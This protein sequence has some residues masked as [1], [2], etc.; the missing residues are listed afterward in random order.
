MPTAVAILVI[1]LWWEGAYDHLQAPDFWVKVPGHGIDD[2][3]RGTVA[4]APPVFNVTLRVDNGV[5]RLPFCTGR[6]SA[7]VAYAGV[8][9]AHA[10]LPTGFCVPGRVVSS[11]P[12][13]ATSDGLG[14]PDELYERMESQ[15][16]RHERVS[17]EVQVKLEDCDGC[18]PFPAMLWCIAV[19][20]GQPQEGPF[21]CPFFYMVK[22]GQRSPCIGCF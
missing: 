15:R 20:H 5:T 10:D 6:A 16:R 7:V 18:G 13:V 21:R 1:H 4:V 9:L 11:V 14:I 3:E 19:L 8:Q 22:G 17:L 2:L 12:I